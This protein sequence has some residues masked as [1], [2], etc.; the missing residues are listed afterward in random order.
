MVVTAGL[1]E[2]EPFTGTGTGAALPDCSVALAPFAVH[3][4]VDVAPR[5]MLFGVAVKL[6]MAVAGSAVM[7]MS[8]VTVPQA[9]GAL[10]V[11]VV[12]PTGVTMTEPIFGWTPAT[13]LIVTPAL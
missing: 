11:Y 6:V 5:L 2:S 7:T 8:C 4:S 13:P 1:T 9:F 3:V 10:S 12:V